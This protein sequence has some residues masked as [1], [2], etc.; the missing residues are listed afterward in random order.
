MELKKVNVGNKGMSQ[1]YSISKD[2]QEYAFENRNIRIQALDDNTLL[3][4]TNIKGPKKVDNVEIKGTIVGKCIAKDYLV[5]FTVDS[6]SVCYIYRIDFNNTSIVTNILYQGNDLHFEK[7]RT[8]D[9]LFYYEN[10]NVQK[11]YW[12][13]S[14]YSEKE[15]ITHPNSVNNPPRYINIITEGERLGGDFTSYTKNIFDFYPSIDKT[16][17]FNIKKEYTMLSEL[18]SG[19]IQYFISYYFDNGAETLIAN[20]SSIFT[21]D[22][23]NRGAKADENGSCG[24]TITIKNIDTKFDYFR[25]YSAVKTAKDGSIIL[26]IVE[27]VKVNK[28]NPNAEYIIKDGGINQETLQD[29]QLFFIGGTPFYAKTLEQK[30]N[31]LFFGNLKTNQ[32]QIPNSIKYIL[33]ERKI[34]TFK[35]NKIE[36]PI[37]KLYK[38]DSIEYYT[39]LEKYLELNEK[40][41]TDE[42]K[43][44]YKEEYGNNYSKK[45]Y[46]DCVV[47]E[48]QFITLGINPETYDQVIF[49]ECSDIQFDYKQHTQEPSNAFSQFYNYRL[50]T[51]NSDKSYKTFKSGEMYRF[52]IQFQTKEG[53]WTYVFWLGDKEC[54]NYPQVD[55]EKHILKLNTVK[56][57]FKGISGLLPQCEEHG[58]SSYRLV[59]ADPE[60]QNGRRVIAQGV[61]CPTLFSPGQRASGMNYSMSSWIMRPRGFKTSYNHWEP[62]GS[63]FSEGA[64]IF[65]YDYG[66]VGTL[67]TDEENSYFD[68]SGFRKGKENYPTPYITI[69]KSEDTNTEWTIKTIVTS[70][71]VGA[72]AKAWL[73][74]NAVYSNKTIDNINWSES[75]TYSIQQLFPTTSGTQHYN[76]TGAD[77]WVTLYKKLYQAF[78]QCGLDSKTVPNPE[79]LQ[80]MANNALDDLKADT[81]EELLHPVETYKIEIKSEIVIKGFRQLHQS[82]PYGFPEQLLTSVFI[83]QPL[84]ARDY[85]Q[86][87]TTSSILNYSQKDVDNQMNHFYVDE[88]IVTFHS[89]DLVDNNSFNALFRIVGIAPIDSIYSNLEVQTSTIP[90]ISNGG[91]IQHPILSRRIINE[92]IYNGLYSDYLY[93]DGYIQDSG[94]IDTETENNKKSKVISNIQADY[95]LYL[96]DKQGS[97]P[98][99][100]ND[101]KKFDGSDL[102][103]LPSELKTKTF[104]N[105][106][107]SFG[108]IY[109]SEYQNYNP[110]KIAVFNGHSKD[111]ITLSTDNRT[112]I[113]NGNYD[114]MIPV[115][116][117]VNLYKQNGILGIDSIVNSTVRIKYD[118][119]PHAVFDLNG[120]I[121][122]EKQL[123][124]KV[125]DELGFDYDK[126]IK[127]SKD[128][129]WDYTNKQYESLTA[130][131]ISEED[132]YKDNSWFSIIVSGTLNPDET[133]LKTKII[134]NLNKKK[135]LLKKYSKNIYIGFIYDSVSSNNVDDYLYSF[136][137]GNT[138]SNLVYKLYKVETKDSYK[139]FN[140]ELTIYDINVIKIKED[141][142]LCDKIFIYE[143][144]FSY[145]RFQWECTGGEYNGGFKIYNRFPITYIQN[146]LTLPSEFESVSSYLFIGELYHNTE[147]RHLY[148]GYN[149]IDNLV[150]YPIS[151]NTPI[152]KDITKTSGD[153]YYQ[154]WDCLKTIPKTEEDRNKVVDITSFMVE[155]RRNLDMRTDVNRGNFNMMSRPSNFNLFNSVYDFKNNLFQYTTLNSTLHTIEYPNQITWSLKK[156]FIGKTDSWVNT[157]MQSITQCSSPITK[158]INYNNQLLSFNE[159]SIEVINYNNKNL[160]ASSDSTFIELANNSNVDGTTKLFTVYGTHNNSTLITEKGLYFIEDNENSIIRFSTDGSL[161][162]LGIGKMDSWL[163][164]NIMP[165]SYTAKDA[166]NYHLEYDPIHKDIYI[167]GNGD[168]LIY[169]EALDSFTSFVD[170][171]ELYTMFSINSKL[172][173]INNED[174]SL[175]QMFEGDYNKGFMDTPLNYSIEY[176]VNPDPYSD[177]V[178]T[179]LEFIADYGSE[180]Q[181]V[182]D[183]IKVWNEYQDTGEVPLEFKRNYPSNLKQKFRIWRADIPRDANSKWK[184]DRIRNPWIHLKLTKNPTDTNKMEF[185]SMNVQYML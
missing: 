64:E 103:E 60:N 57:N 7:D 20:N 156:N 66:Y 77:R 40:E 97:I 31:T 23:P 47:T 151:T 68:E 5:L 139:D 136:L 129:K 3:S 95:K 127:T 115:K 126:I 94:N 96:W 6:Q 25:I 91:I 44:Q 185:H 90:Y 54:K 148:G 18:P 85:M 17:E 92:P 71:S 10:Q 167:I 134:D 140:N 177:K 80:R 114:Y 89:P 93:A 61:V 12:V 81:I 104:F 124:P 15:L 100:T 128:H 1:D 162:K 168:C 145:G 150:W 98:G 180:G 13:E 178:F 184:R 125:G 183:T 131:W 39:T 65:G 106:L 132:I 46:S 87:S 171:S 121:R 107:N 74:I 42:Q 38:E 147:A 70:L 76:E 35:N 161:F 154:R 75:D 146:T 29:N 118:S 157:S 179:N 73:K 72:G 9:T 51:E 160:L 69:K 79:T 62:I 158:L 181:Q 8:F 22:Y 164:N 58:F 11:V 59:I 143:N 109:V 174:R 63:S 142:G 26:K 111:T 56:Y 102:L 119:T 83:D 43:D 34:Y 112:L 108:N 141:G 130:T 182:F 105:Q 48:K 88:S 138:P 149:T 49:V 110:S 37:K 123:L 4:I 165:F 116:E 153:T 120:A 32:V 133:I 14:W 117:G 172:Y 78:E 169:N 33:E 99:V 170:Y 135:T 152:N 24:F 53:Q 27:D 84:S 113:Y 36:L 55:K 159:K 137:K 101:I 82:N 19:T 67:P 41:L 28:Q 175:Y 144:T 50:Q 166:N 30:D 2:S 155:T 21:I 16:P 163:K 176:R 122:G 86:I 52:G 173:A 45:F